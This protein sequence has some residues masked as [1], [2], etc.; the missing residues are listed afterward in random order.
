MQNVENVE[1]IFT[2][3]LLQRVFTIARE[4]DVAYG[5]LCDARSAA[6]NF[7][8]HPWDTNDNKKR[9]LVVGTIYVKWNTPNDLSATLYKFE[10]EKEGRSYLEVRDLFDNLVMEAH[11]R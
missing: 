2:K 3:E 7:W 6:I 8:S 1:E 9:S 11:Q 4:K 10:W 5:G